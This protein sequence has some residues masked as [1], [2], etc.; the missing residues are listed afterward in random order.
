V[1]ADLVRYYVARGLSAPSLNAVDEPDSIGQAIHLGKQ[2]IVVEVW[3]A[4]E[5]NDRLPLA[6]V[7]IISRA[8]F[9]REIFFTRSRLVWPEMK[10]HH[11]PP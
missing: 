9:D 2:L 10:A 11:A 7:A 5:D 8:V 4:R 3:P 1:D 6:D